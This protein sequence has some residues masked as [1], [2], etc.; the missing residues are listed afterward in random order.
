MDD[1]VTP[2]DKILF[3]IYII[4]RENWI[5]FIIT[6]HTPETTNDTLK[7]RRNITYI[8]VNENSVLKIA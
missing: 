2:F 8:F 7:D 4:Y 1:F 3:I 5:L 6:P